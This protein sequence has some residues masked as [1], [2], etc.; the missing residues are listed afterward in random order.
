MLLPLAL[1]VLATSAWAGQCTF[2]QFQG[3]SGSISIQ[4]LPLSNFPAY[5]SFKC[6]SDVHAC[7]SGCSKCNP[8][9]AGSCNDKTTADDDGNPVNYSCF[10]NV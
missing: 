3:C 1:V 10:K 2:Y 8:I 6:N 5:S 9:D 4:N 7:Y